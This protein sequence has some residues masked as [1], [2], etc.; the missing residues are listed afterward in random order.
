MSNI[1]VVTGAG[2]SNDCASVGV[3]GA[4][5]LTK[6]LFGDAYRLTLAEYP[7]VRQA[8]A[9]IRRAMQESGENAIALEDF[10]RERMAA[11]ASPYTQ[12]RYRQVPLY[13]QA[14]LS[15]ASGFTAE[16]DNYN[17]LVNAALE[18]DEALFLTLNY[19]TLLDGRFAEYWPLNDRDWYVDQ[20]SRWSLVKLHGSVNWG[21]RL[22]LLKKH[23]SLSHGSI[24]T[25]NE[26]IDD[27][28]VAGFPQFN[29]DEIELRQGPLTNQ[30]WDTSEKPA[31]YYPALAVPLG[32]ADEIV[33]PSH[34]VD[35]AKQSLDRMDGIN[36]LV[37]GYSG[38]DEEVL[39]LFSESGNSIRRML[40]AN[41]DEAMA[42]TAAEQIAKA[43]GANDLPDAWVSS[44]GFTTLVQSGEL[45]R[46]M[47]E[48]AGS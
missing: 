31:I 29:N 18:L 21:W 41:G 30:R 44:R 25:A 3:A 35:V 34:H 4:P 46:W 5:P 14:V 15:V 17:A 32:S 20:D 7:L 26:V 19:D 40:V 16:P 2:A 24:D 22:E 27:Y 37:I 47:S 28:V 42:R 6:D 38:A 1:V 10:L 45:Q 33:C 9:D 13:L 43:L 8:A 23:L 48:E 39:R 11:S 36:L 12:R